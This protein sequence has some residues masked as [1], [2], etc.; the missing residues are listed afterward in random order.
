[1]NDVTSSDEGRLPLWRRLY[2]WYKRSHANWWLG[3]PLVFAGT[4]S[5]S[6]SEKYPGL[7]EAA[8]TAPRYSYEGVITRPFRSNRHGYDIGLE[9]GE[10][11]RIV[12]RPKTGRR[13]DCLSGQDFPLVANV[14]LFNYNGY[15]TILEV[16]NLSE[17]IIVTEKSQMGT[18]DYTERS[19][20]EEGYISEFI[21]GY[22]VG[23]FLAIPASLL[24]A[25]LFQFVRFEKFLRSRQKGKDA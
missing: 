12:C 10:R 19:Q 22:V 6:A 14:T 5:F 2:Q 23:L 9:N 13:G 16:K 17:D 4:F 8:R 25:L 18:L 11:H 24:F 20:D 21:F 15:Q 1:M 3:F 7:G